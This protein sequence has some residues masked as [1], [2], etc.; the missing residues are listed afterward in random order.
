MFLQ[1]PDNGVANIGLA[2]EKLEVEKL[3][4]P[5]LCKKISDNFPA[6]TPGFIDMRLS[7]AV[8]D[9]N[10][11]SILQSVIAAKDR[12]TLDLV[13]DRRDSILNA[14]EFQR[15]EITTPDMIDYSTPAYRQATSSSP[16]FF[17]GTDSRNPYNFLA[18]AEQDAQ[19]IIHKLDTS[20]TTI[21]EE[22]MDEV[23]RDFSLTEHASD[24]SD[25]AFSRF[26]TSN[27]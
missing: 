17:K 22:F 13:L 27:K 11:M 21:T 2:L 25:L 5:E 7:K 3:L 8:D 23:N 4:A 9:S 12:E 18:M 16:V 10:R 1:E 14:P 26:G 19:R 20:I 6:N 15:S 24:V